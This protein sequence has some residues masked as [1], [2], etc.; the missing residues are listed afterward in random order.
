MEETRQA[1]EDRLQLE[2]VKY[3]DDME[4]VKTDAHMQ[5]SRARQEFAEQVASM[6]SETEKSLERERARHKVGNI[7]GD[8]VPICFIQS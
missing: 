2:Q 4:A 8:S 6:R 1:Y 5:S 3:R 7:T